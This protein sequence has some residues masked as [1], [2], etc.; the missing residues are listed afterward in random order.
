MKGKTKPKIHFDS[1]GGSGPLGVYWYDGPYG[2]A[3][4]CLEGDGV[5]F[6]SP[7]GE[8]LGA[9]F[10]DV[11]ESKDDQILISPL[12]HQIHVIVTNKKVDVELKQLKRRA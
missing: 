6:L 8:L 12:G 9:I 5:V 2:L 4:E 1:F 7:N 3:K 10:D 11:E